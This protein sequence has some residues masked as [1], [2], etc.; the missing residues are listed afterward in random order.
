[1]RQNHLFFLA[2][3]WFLS[4]ASLAAQGGAIADAQPGARAGRSATTDLEAEFVNPPNKAKTWIYWWWPNGY[5]SELGIVRDLDEMK[6]KGISGALV[7]QAR[8]GETPVRIEFMSD[9]WLKLFRFAVEEAAKRDITIT[10][11]LCDAWNATGPWVT[12]EHAP[13][14]LHTQSIETH[15]PRALSHKFLR[16][17]KLDHYE[18]LFVFAWREKDGVCQ[19]DSWIDL[20]SQ[21]KGSGEFEWQAPE[22]Q[23]RIVL[24]GSYIHPSAH[25]GKLLETDPLN[26]AAMDVHFQHTVVPAVQGLEKYLGKTFTHVHIDSGEIGNPDWTPKFR[27]EFRRLRGYDPFPYFAAKANLAVDSADT[28]ERFLEDYERTIGDLMIEC[29]YGYLGELAAK[30]GL[31]THSEAAGYQK[32][33]V[34]AL[35]A[36]G[37]NDISM[38]EFWSRNVMDHGRYIHQL[39][40]SQLQYH[41]GIK[42]AASAAHA[43][44]RPIVQAEA[45]TVIIRGPNFYGDLFSLKDI[46]DRAFCQGLNRMVL[47]NFI[48][49]PESDDRAPG[50]LWPGIGVEF[51]RKATWWPM[52]K[53]WFDYLNRCQYLHQ[54]GRSVA[55]VCYFQGDWVPAYVP[56]KWAMNPPLPRGY[57]CDTINAEAMIHRMKVDE[58]GRL[59][60]PEGLTYRYLVLNQAGP[61]QRPSKIFFGPIASTVAKPP[62]RGSG[63][64][65]A[66]SPASLHKLEELIEAGATVIGPK[67]SRTI[68]LS[69][70][71]KEEADAKK[72]I[73]TLWAGAPDNEVA[74]SPAGNPQPGQRRVG[75][76]RVIWNRSLDEVMQSDGLLPDLEIRE[77]KQTQSLPIETFG[78][79]PSPGTFDWIH[80][81][82]DAADFY[83]L[84]NLRNAPAAGDFTFRVGGKQP[85]FWDPITGEIRDLPQYTS[86]AD[87]RTSLTLEFAPRQCYFVVF[88]KVTRT[89]SR[90]SFANFPRT[91]PLCELAGPW[92]VHFDPKWGGPESVVFEKLQD[93]TTR[94][95]EGIK[96]YS[97]IATYRK[98]FDLPKSAAGDRTYLDL[99]KVHDMARVRLNGKDLGVVWCAPWRVE[100]THAVQPKG[101]RLEIDVADLWRNRLI[102]DA[103]LPVK[104]R[105]T[106]SNL[107]HE[108]KP[109]MRLL[110]SGLLGPLTLSQ[111]ASQS[112]Q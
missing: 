30:Y 102:G 59:C 51:N 86:N 20:T 62:Q 107:E 88:R 73:E 99:G 1:M 28:T 34:D 24:Y 2:G 98:T 81:T 93:W 53:A 108:F 49:Q 26:K 112:A 58:Q 23:W 36:L 75:K 106:T 7:F 110:P 90:Q 72:L 96:H 111:S 63:K 103:G 27:Q 71:P 52:A 60:L 35:R 68:G 56:A 14:V 37:C 109:K 32:P 16:P 17:E 9:R 29:Y 97:G 13:K 95:E 54:K 43:Y 100:I 10:L 50:Y 46:G 45:Y 55:N 12:S 104:Q 19:R 101:N 15:G 77:S 80:R 44:G 25:R 89:A 41:D 79:I 40:E 18:N 91:R 94:P 22:G 6:S 33:T 76:G 39:A 82:I 67:P 65:L 11:N 42:T 31:K 105:W 84:A 66:L 64:P 57:D 21:L 5:V 3:L 69:Y 83:F 74:K 87:G 78:G 38:S 47:H 61:W 92:Q 4:C 8:A 85:E 70:T 48:L